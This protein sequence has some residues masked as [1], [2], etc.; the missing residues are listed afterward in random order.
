M[1]WILVCDIIA[2]DLQKISN[3]G[4][5]TFTPSG[6]KLC[7]GGHSANV[8][9]DLMKLGLQKGSVSSIGAIGNDIF[10][11]FIEEELK[12]YDM[13]ELIV[14]CYSVYSNS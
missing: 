11:E 6:I 10:G 8:S 12:K 4:E 7:I 2:A 9:I 3:P 1:C 13:F 5:V 14:K